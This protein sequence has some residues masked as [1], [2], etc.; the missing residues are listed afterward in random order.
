MFIPS[1]GSHPSK[2]QQQQGSQPPSLALSASASSP[3]SKGLLLARF[4]GFCSLVSKRIDSQGLPSI[5]FVQAWE[6]E[7]SQLPLA[8]GNL[9]KGCAWWKIFGNERPIVSA[10][11]CSRSLAR[12]RGRN[13]VCTQREKKGRMKR[14][15]LL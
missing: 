7:Q 15:P 9:P 12:G 6:L 8:V 10:N 3:A 14:A 1:D 13:D 11:Y 5:S 4:C 2:T